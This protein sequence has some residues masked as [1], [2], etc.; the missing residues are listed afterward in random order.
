MSF[1]QPNIETSGRWLRGLSSFVL[2]VLA[3]VTWSLNGPLLLL[4]ALVGG[5][6][7]TALE[8]A[9][10]WCLARACGIKTKF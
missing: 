8:A 2:L 4:I 5:S 10:G 7:F 6:L 9:R 1:F 3:V